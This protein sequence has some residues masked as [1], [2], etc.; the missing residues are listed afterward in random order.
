MDEIKSSAGD[1]THEY[2]F[3]LF[4]KLE[5]NYV[6]DKIAV[7]EGF[8][9]TTYVLLSIE[10]SLVVFVI[11]TIYKKK[12]GENNFLNRISNIVSP[13]V[14]PPCKVL[15]PKESTG[16]L[17]FVPQSSSPKSEDSDDIDTFKMAKRCTI[18]LPFEC[19]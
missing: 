18:P 17:P 4:G 10:N 15:S 14:P 3:E 13:K 12:P 2:C 8:Q 7:F 11:H 19:P 6:P 1:K 16:K 5:L 9:G